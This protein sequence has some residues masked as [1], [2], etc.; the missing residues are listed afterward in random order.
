MK[1]EC[2]HLGQLTGEAARLVDHGVAAVRWRMGAVDSGRGQGGQGDQTVCPSQK[3][4][5]VG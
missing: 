3:R 5:K 4:R 1:V 2:R